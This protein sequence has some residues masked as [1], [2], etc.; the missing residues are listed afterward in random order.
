MNA[1]QLKDG[2]QER[3]KAVLKTGR[4]EPDLLGRSSSVFRDAESRLRDITSN[5]I[6]V[7]GKFG[8]W[9]A[10]ANR[11][12]K[13]IAATRNRPLR[14]PYALFYRESGSYKYVSQ[15]HVEASSE[16]TVG[17]LHEVVRTHI[18]AIPPYDGETRHKIIV[19]E[20]R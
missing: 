6:F 10:P 7:F 16:D 3:Y 4:L 8:F 18:E 17:F 13:T 5:L 14:I 2:Y 19:Y 1:L 20:V 11:T 12:K 9:S 15:N